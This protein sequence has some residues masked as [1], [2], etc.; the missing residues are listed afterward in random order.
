MTYS[1]SPRSKIESHLPIS[2][3]H[4]CYCHSP[5]KGCSQQDTSNE[6]PEGS[7]Y[8]HTGAVTSYVRRGRE[9]VSSKQIIRHVIRLILYTTH[10]TSSVLR[11]IL[12][13]YYIIAVG[14]FGPW[15]EERKVSS[16]E[17][18][19]L[20]FFAWSQQILLSLHVIYSVT[21]SKMDNDWMGV[22]RKET[23]QS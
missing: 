21:Y 4:H 11:D 5:T 7:T 22:T 20:A 19:N 2:S 17:S 12:Y 23:L 15:T 1:H 8:S 3:I 18:A 9:V 13:H 14:C 16:M 6:A 10:D